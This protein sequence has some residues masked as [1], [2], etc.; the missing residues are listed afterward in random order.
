MTF[1]ERFWSKVDTTGD[2][3]EWTAGLG[4]GYGQFSV[5]G[6]PRRAYRVALELAGLAPP[7]SSHIHHICRNRRCVR[8]DHL[9]V[10]A[11]QAEHSARHR[12]N[13]GK[14]GDADIREIL[15]GRNVGMRYC[16]ACNR[17]KALKVLRAK[18]T[19]TREQYLDERFGLDRPGRRSGSDARLDALLSEEAA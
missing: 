13:C 11:T 17:E 3:W 1:F 2:C 5:N 4:N 18:G 12:T 7:P 16:A 8:P 9:E 6:R 15:S 10:L 19:P 14:H